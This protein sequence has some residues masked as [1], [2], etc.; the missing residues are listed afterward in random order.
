[1]T[2]RRISHTHV[3]KFVERLGNYW[4]YKCL[5]CAKGF[6]I[7]KWGSISNLVILDKQ[8]PKAK[9]KPLKPKRKRKG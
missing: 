9:E 8:F 5:Y 2:V 1:M 7:D 3:F 4:H 6:S